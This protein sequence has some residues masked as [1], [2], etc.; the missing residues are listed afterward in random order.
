MIVT[1]WQI[2]NLQCYSELSKNEKEKLLPTER[3]I[4]LKCNYEIMHLN[5]FTL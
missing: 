1:A 2:Y 3:Y 5:I 4:F